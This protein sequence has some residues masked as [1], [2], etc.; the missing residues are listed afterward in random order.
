MGGWKGE[1]FGV[2]RLGSVGS[3]LLA[4]AV[5]AEGV[6]GLAVVA[7]G[8][9]PAHGSEKLNNWVEILTTHT[10]NNR[11]PTLTYFCGTTT[12]AQGGKKTGGNQKCRMKHLRNI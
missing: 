5:L 9:S 3:A 10:P 1:R 7:L 4:L 8:T 6:R 11:A 2:G 12:G